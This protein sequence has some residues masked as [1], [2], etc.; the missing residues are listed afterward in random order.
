MRFAI[1]DDE[2]VQAALLQG[3]VARWCARRQLPCQIQVYVSAEALLFDWDGQEAAD[4]LLLDIL[5]GP[6]NGMELAKQLRS[7]RTQMQI[8]FITGTPDFVFEGYQVE[9]VSYLMKPVQEE[10]LSRCL[11]QACRRAAAEIPEVLA[12]TPAG[13]R[14]VRLPELCYLESFGHSTAL[15]TSGGV[16]ESKTGIQI[17]DERLHDKG[18][19]RLH[20]S[21]LISLAHVAAITKKEVELDGGVR[22]PIPRGKWEDVN[23]AYLA[24]FGKKTQWMAGMPL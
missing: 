11:E 2:A 18:F 19:F 14:R 10:Q 15:H 4:V 3:M 7:R 20:R 21:Y 8:I 9:A 12:D 23:R 6:M 24:Y 13:V 17:W 16:L 1:C 22:L 5:M